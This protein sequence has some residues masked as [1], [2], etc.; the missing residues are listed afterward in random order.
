MHHA[1]TVHLTIHGIIVI[2][3]AL[4]LTALFT[5]K[6]Y[7]LKRLYLAAKTY[8]VTD[9]LTG[10]LNRRQLF[11]TLEAEIQRARRYKHNTQIMFMDVD[12]FKKFNDRYGHSAGDK[13][14]TMVAEVL[15]SCVRKYD[16]AARLAGDEFMLILPETS[17]EF[18]LKIGERILEKIKKLEVGGGSLQISASIGICQVDVFNDVDPMEAADAAMYATKSKGKGQI[19]VSR[20]DD[21]VIR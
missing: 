18:S 1:I 13:V 11:L 12:N 7:K 3:C 14:L 17:L 20:S 19:A 15:R 5:V 16:T 10:L 6:Y 4:A 2:I 21:R 9:P 8:A